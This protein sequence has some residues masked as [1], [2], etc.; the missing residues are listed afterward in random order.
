M[1]K[2]ENKK[3][4]LKIVEAFVAIMLI[5]ATLLILLGR[6]ESD[7][8]LEREI[9][10]LQTNL[11]SSISKDDNLREEILSSASLIKTNEYISKNIPSWLDYKIQV[12]E[13]DNVCALTGVDS[14]VLAEKQIYSQNILI[15]ATSQN[16]D[17]KQLKLFFWRK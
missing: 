6:Q 14:K 11:L 17:S 15:L 13:I 4:W 3:G 9:T 7:S 2:L 5:L 12:C 16:A 10:L 1:I 8:G